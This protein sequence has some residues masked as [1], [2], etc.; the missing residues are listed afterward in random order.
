M[1]PVSRVMSADFTYF[2]PLM[3][4]QI[5]NF[6]NLSLHLILAG[7][8]VISGCSQEKNDSGTD[9]V[10]STKES[11]AGS[12]DSKDV[13]IEAVVSD[14]LRISGRTVVFFGPSE[15]VIE[16]LKKKEPGRKVAA[17]Q[18]QFSDAIKPV[19]DSLIAA[20]FEDVRYTDKRFIQV[21][22]RTGTEMK[23]DRFKLKSEFGMYMT[24]GIQPPALKLGDLTSKEMHETLKKFFNP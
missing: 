14:T 3:K 20:G 18:Q 13:P 16:L 4:K 7:G 21:T 1:W 17:E 9:A 2:Y 8:L 6:R 15:E 23:I 11:P 22:M 12:A 10:N 5:I 19:M 24:D